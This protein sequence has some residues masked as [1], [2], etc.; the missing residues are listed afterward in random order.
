MI[1]VCFS[2]CS[3]GTSSDASDPGKKDKLHIVTTIFP[4]YDW[5]M[6]ILG[7][8]AANADVTLLLNNGVDL[9]S[10]QP[11]AADI[12]KISTCDLFIYVGGESDQW[13]EDVLENAANEDMVVIN[14]LD[15]LG[16]QAREEELAPGMQGEEEA[17]E[18]DGPAFDEQVWLSLRNAMVFVK[19]IADVLSSMDGEHTGYYS[20]NAAAYIEK[21]VTLDE[22]Y[23]EMVA[24]AKVKTLLFGDRFPFLYMVN[25]YA[26]SYFAAF[27]G[28]SA[29]TEASFETISF[30]AGKVDELSLH[31]VLTIDGSDQRIAETIIQNTKTKDQKILTLDAM[32][33]TTSEDISNGAT[34][35]SIME[36]NLDIL[37]EALK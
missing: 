30:L 8:D 22:E 23:K 16:D 27:A 10:F 36:H 9:H 25:D 13:V 29:E 6:N 17:E 24:G 26:L 15:V 11:T 7:D 19:A 12:L 4:E 5:V 18:E 14:L 21:L 37:R 20:A 33:G 3:S 2:G 28:C 1:V 32:Q 35:L 31:C 34:Y